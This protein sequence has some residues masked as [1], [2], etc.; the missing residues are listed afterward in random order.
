MITHV[1]HIADLHI[2][3]G[4]TEQSRF[5]EY[6][7]VFERFAQ[8]VESHPATKE[9]RA[10]V[11][12]AGDVFHHKL[13]IESPGLKL[14]LEFFQSLGA[15]CPVYVIRGNHDYRQDKPHEPDLIQ[16]LNHL[17]NIH[18]LDETGV[19]SIDDIGFGVVT[20]QDSLQKGATVGVANEL[21]LFPSPAFESTV[22]HKIALFHGNVAGFPADWFPTGYDV[23]MLGDIHVQQVT[24]AK[25]S[26]HAV[27]KP[28]HS[29]VTSQY[30]YADRSSDKSPVYG[31]AGSM[32]QQD[33]GE[34]ILGHGY[35]LW[36]LKAKMVDCFHLNND[37]GFLT[38]R[39]HAGKDAWEIQ[40][41]RT[42]SWQPLAALVCE[43]WFPRNTSLRI[44][45]GDD[46]T[47]GVL[48]RARDDFTALGI[49]VSHV[50]SMNTSGPS[51][52]YAAPTGTT[53]DDIVSFN[54]PETWIEYVKDKLG[55]SVPSSAW[56]GW[57]LSPETVQLPMCERVATLADKVKD[58]NAKLDKK[59]KDFV[60]ARDSRKI[61]RSKFRFQYMSWDWIL[62]FRG[63]NW[64]NFEDIAQHDITVVAAKNGVGKTSLLETLCIGMYGEGFPTRTN[65]AFSAS[66]LCQEKPK[67]EKAQTSV[68]VRLGNDT[69]RVRRV[70]TV[71][72]ADPTKLSA[73]SKE[74]T[75]DRVDADDQMVNLYSGK[76]AVDEWVDTH[77]G[78]I[79]SF[80]LSCMITQGGDYDFFNMKSADQKE[81]LDQALDI[82][83][84][85]LFQ[86]VLKEAK[87]AHSS[88]VELAEA[89]L[90]AKP[91]LV[92]SNETEIDSFIE[93]CQAELAKQRLLQQDC[94]TELRDVNPAELKSFVPT[95][96]IEPFEEEELET[97]RQQ[98]CEVLRVKGGT[99]A[100]VSALRKLGTKLPT[101]IPKVVKSHNREDITTELA[102]L[103]KQG[104]VAD[105]EDI[106][107][108]EDLQERLGQGYVP[109]PDPSYDDRALI[110]KYGKDMTP[111]NLE[112]KVNKHLAAK[113]SDPSMPRHVAEQRVA[114]AKPVE[115]ATGGDEASLHELVER[116]E[117]LNARLVELLSNQPAK[118]PTKANPPNGKGKTRQELEQEV[119]DTCS[120]RDIGRLHNLIADLE[121]LRSRYQSAESSLNEALMM[122]KEL[123]LHPYNG[124]CWACQQQ[125]WKKQAVGLETK[126]F[127]LESELKTMKKTIKKTSGCKDI[128]ELAEYTDTLRTHLK[129]VEMLHV[130]EWIEFERER[131]TI[132]KEQTE[133][134]R[135]IEWLKW[136]EAHDASRAW[137]KAD[138]WDVKRQDLERDLAALRR[139]DKAILYRRVSCARMAVLEHDL[140]ACDAADRMRAFEL[141]DKLEDLERRQ[142]ALVVGQAYKHY[143]IKCE[144]DKSIVLLESR[145]VDLQVQK[146]LAD[147]HAQSAEET[148]VVSAYHGEMR[149]RLELLQTIHQVF[150]GFKA[151]VYTQKVVPY[152][153]TFAN[154]IIRVMCENTRPI[155]LVGKMVGGNPVWFMSDGAVPP[156]EKASGFQKFILGLGI[157]IALAKFGTSGMLCS[158]LFID[159][160]FT[161]CDSDNIGRVPTFLKYLLSMYPHGILL[162]SHLDD[163]KACATYQIQLQRNPLDTT[164]LCSFG[165]QR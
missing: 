13:R 31:Y 118:P 89:H 24:G 105:E 121:V 139:M 41:K 9:G 101:V 129:N 115:V 78:D 84:C 17:P 130:L 82:E 47:N 49:T 141:K 144:L 104:F 124:D 69:Y 80:L 35:L 138:T 98:L 112:A 117:T 42:G 125:P 157:R 88:L 72:T 126:I 16:S 39:L 53:T 83:S 37:Y 64:F 86:S 34:G 6:K 26:P 48:K 59:I 158:Q 10:I 7:V 110:D 54:T 134:G 140:E 40:I 73:V 60:A 2:R 44:V 56:Q 28:P 136:K 149:A 111:S 159:E 15:L 43:P 155:Q 152:L 62:C 148:R 92:E 67:G 1:F 162:V 87:T 76:T 151:W 14:A 119:E 45:M 79:R 70:M 99:S 164:T 163:V 55:E 25:S 106:A 63:G 113:P 95:N 33:Y 36:D 30:T 108:L 29:H 52:C 93:S 100:L 94:V 103:S 150:D 161:A 97:T 142:R 133:L 135:H 75:V 12:V 160:G 147:E 4:N 27:H 58:R 102:S 18:Y 128:V 137:R 22:K 154:S 91:P 68:F 21:P 156:I 132:V 46:D 71:S 145:I 90:S 131:D 65:K 153:T 165:S 120:E 123:E 107:V 66:I 57:F 85:A 74:T 96:P 116:F 23:M 19:F 11:V 143:T 77:I 146:K 109:E 5:P 32:V 8:D 122:K 114:A 61:T 20:V 51:D 38:T 3:A 81:M 50:T 127:A